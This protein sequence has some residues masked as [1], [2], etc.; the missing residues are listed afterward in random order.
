MLLIGSSLNLELRTQLVGHQRSSKDLIRSRTAGRNAP[1]DAEEERLQGAYVN[2]VPELAPHEPLSPELVLVLPAELRAEVLA[3]LGPPVW[4][5][6][7]PPA[8]APPRAVAAPLARPVRQLVARPVPQPVSR[9]VAVP[10][11][12]SVATLLATRFAQLALIFVV[13]TILTLA[14]SIVAQAFR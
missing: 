6:P 11:A 8:P 4:A 9:P 13:V 3:A 7:R 10:V 12:R 5:M 1:A 14:M 2:T